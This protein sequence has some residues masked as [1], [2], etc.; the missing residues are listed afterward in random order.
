[1][2]GCGQILTGSDPRIT[3]CGHQLTRD[4]ERM[5]AATLTKPAKESP[6]VITLH[7]DLLLPNFMEAEELG[8]APARHC[9]SCRD[10]SQ[11][12]YRGRMISRDEEQVVKRVED[13]MWVDQ[14]TK[15]IHMSYPWKPEAELQTNNYRQANVI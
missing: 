5:T 4:A 3:R 7:A 11:C 10:C 8:T 9:K 6:Q 12:S 1:M 15:K 13:S 14:V 2:F